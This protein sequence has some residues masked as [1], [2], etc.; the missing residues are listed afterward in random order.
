MKDPKKQ[1]N[2]KE[3]FLNQLEKFIDNFRFTILGSVIYGMSFIAFK[4]FN[5]VPTEKGT[6]G[7]DFLLLVAA[8]QLMIMAIESVSI[9]F[10]TLRNI[11]N[12]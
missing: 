11:F 7:A 2:F 10:K 3:E 9:L 12:S 1:R 6:L 5:L 8:M 4:V